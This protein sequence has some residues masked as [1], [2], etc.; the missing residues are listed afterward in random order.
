MRLFLWVSTCLATALALVA[1]AMLARDGRA[2]GGRQPPAKVAAGAPPSLPTAR[3]T[4][5]ALAPR[6]TRTRPAPEASAAASPRSDGP[7]SPAPAAPAEG[8]FPAPAGPAAARTAPLAPAGEIA[9]EAILERIRA[10]EAG[11]EVLASRLP[12]REL[13]VAPAWKEG[14]E[15]IVETFYRQMQA[16]REV[17]TGPAPW[18]FRVERAVSYA[19]RPCW[20]IVVSRDDDPAFEPAAF[21]MTR[22]GHRL[23]A[24]EVTATVQGK[25][26]R[27]AWRFDEEAPPDAGTKAPFTIIPLDLPPEGARARVEPPGL[28]FDREPPVPGAAAGA[29]DRARMPPPESL[30]GAGGEY[31]DLSYENPLDRTQVRQRWSR[32]DMRWPVISR[33]ETTWSFRRA[34]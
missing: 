27:V 2:P 28:A 32:A 22:D 5:H 1:I 24:A 25:S 26:R 13:P 34:N 18:R 12:V 3:P 29:A 33:T 11:F 15:W 31:L 21:F 17:W 14:D 20:Q 4:P 10:G 23:V 7:R 6:E 8:L 19:D 9:G 30:V 16:P